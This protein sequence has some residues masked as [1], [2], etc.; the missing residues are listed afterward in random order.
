MLDLVVS[1]A[2]AAHLLTAVPLQSALEGPDFSADAIRGHVEF[3]ADDRLEGR[4]TGTRGFE[5]AALYVAT[6]FRASGL[7][8]AAGDGWFQSTPLAERTPN[9]SGGSLTVGDRRFLL[10]EHALAA[11]AGEGPQRWSGEAVFA[12]YGLSAPEL[13]ID[14]YRGLDVRGKAVVVVNGGPASLP[15]DVVEGLSR[16]R[17]EMAHARGAAG[18]ITLFD[19]EPTRGTWAEWQ[20]DFAAPFF[21]WLRADG[22]PWRPVPMRFS[23]VLDAVAAGGLFDGA[24]LDSAGIAARGSRGEP[25]RGF[26]LSQRVTIESQNSWRRFTS[27]NVI[28]MVPGTDPALAGECVLVSSHLDHL[29]VD[30]SF[31]GD[32]KIFNGA[33]VNASGVA[34]LLEMARV[35]AASPAQRPVVF[36]ALTAEEI[37]LLGSD[38]LAEHGI[39]ACERIVAVVNID[40]GVPLHELPEAIAYGGWHSTI[41]PAFDAVAAANGIRAGVDETPPADFFERTDHFSFVRRGVPGIYLVMSSGDDE[42]ATSPYRGRYHQPSD[43]LTLPFNWAAGARFARLAHDLV[44]ALADG[45]ETP[46]WYADSPI[47]QRYAPD[48]PKA[49]RP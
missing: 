29:G 9:V 33:L 39:P 47:G 6:Q 45:P 27:P 48:E 19:G 42:E 49:T 36:A 30:P 32:D 31:S 28:G 34:V 25:L 11:I 21:N 35:L 46:R 16:R 26:P 41:G 38:Y 37:G 12:G 4:G 3:L 18:V 15:A 43:D 23:A 17:Y 13:G 40:G 8:P 44:R 24:P 5:V 7:E 10:G 22:E 14:D 20:A 2:L 1:A